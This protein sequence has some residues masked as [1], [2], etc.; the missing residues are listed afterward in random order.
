M[1]SLETA[2]KTLVLAIA[3]YKHNDKKID[4][5]PL[6]EELT[7]EMLTTKNNNIKVFGDNTEL[8]DKILDFLEKLIN[9]EITPDEENLVNIEVSISD[10]PF[11]TKIYDKY[12]HR[13]SINPVVIKNLKKELMNKLKSYTVRKELLKALNILNTKPNNVDMVISELTKRLETIKDREEITIAGLVGEIDFDSEESIKKA[14]E[15][16]KKLAVGSDAFKLGWSCI[17]DMTQGG[18]RRGEFIT[19]SALQHNYKSSFVK[20]I[21]AQ[22]LR[23]NVPKLKNPDKKPLLLFISLEEELNNIF[24]FFYQ[25]LKYSEEGIIYTK[26]E[27]EELSIEETSKYVR[28]KFTA[29]GFSAK[30]LRFNPSY[31]TYERLFELIENYELQGY[32]VQGV[33][34]DYVKK[35]N[36]AGVNKT[37]PSGTDLLELFSIIRNFMSSKNIM[38]VTPHQL[39]TDAKRLQRNGMPPEEFVKFVAHKGYYADSSQLDQEIDLELFLAKARINKKWYLT[40]QR[41]KHRIPTVI[42][43]ELQYAI[44]KFP[45][46]GAPIP[47]ENEKHPDVC[48]KSTTSED[49]YDF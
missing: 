20:S 17:N 35:M 1:T 19:V 33:I 47:E 34:L 14:A 21:F 39:S 12:V 24:L 49:D 45:E 23:L 4:S 29:N 26:R 43:D 6:I 18:F 16:A 8:I 7:K 46:K 25:Y 32:E 30:V 31:L 15:D 48:Q 44:L 36:R 2:F 28:E 40:I 27:L 11:L 22:I 38:F 41:G 9:K 5:L 42:P 10:K 37:G 13:E 3:E